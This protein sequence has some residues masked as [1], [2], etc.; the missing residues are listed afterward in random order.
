MVT[1][2]MMMKIGGGFSNMFFGRDLRMYGIPLHGFTKIPIVGV[3]SIIFCVF[4]LKLG[5]G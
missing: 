3:F 2:N 1:L 5:E 4:T